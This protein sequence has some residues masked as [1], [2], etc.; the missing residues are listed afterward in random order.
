MLSITDGIVSDPKI[1]VHPTISRVSSSRP[2]PI[3]RGIIT[4]HTSAAKGSSTLGGYAGNGKP[5]TSDKERPMGAHFLIDENGTIYQ[6]ARLDRV[7]FH[8]GP[9]RSRCFLFLTCEPSEMAS[10]GTLVGGKKKKWEQVFLTKDV[11]KSSDIE[12]KKSVPERYPSNDDSIGIEITG[13]IKDGM[14]GV[15]TAVQESSLNWLIDALKNSFVEIGDEV[16]PHT[17]VSRKEQLEGHGGSF[18][19]R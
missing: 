3:I 15:V 1:I 16:W 19:D 14:Y 6:T 2:M 9:V 4:H 11:K 8:V 18:N 12:M 5:I 17:A 13:V 10:H 7:A